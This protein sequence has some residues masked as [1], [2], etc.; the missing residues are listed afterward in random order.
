MNRR[1][2]LGG[3]HHAPMLTSRKFAEAAAADAVPASGGGAAAPAWRERR[4]LYPQ[5]VASGDPAPD[6]VLLW[7][8]RPPTGGD[9]RA[10][11][12]VTMELAKDRTFHRRKS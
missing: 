9:P 6:S 5:G 11:Y 2:R 1:A 8:C 4:D 12:L 7:T 10:A 3:R